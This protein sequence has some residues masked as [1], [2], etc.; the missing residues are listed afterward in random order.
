MTSEK[1]A[2]FYTV[3]CGLPKPNNFQLLIHN[4]NYLLLA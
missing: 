2:K 3:Y 4:D 1:V